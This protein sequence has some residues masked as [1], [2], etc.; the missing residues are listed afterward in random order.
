MFISTTNTKWSILSMRA[1]R[2]RMRISLVCG[3]RLI[4]DK[5]PAAKP[6]G[7]RRLKDEQ[8]EFATTTMAS[9]CFGVV[10][11]FSSGGLCRAILLGLFA[12]S[13]RQGMQVGL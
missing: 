13:L 7:W 8:Y 9:H 6:A 11:R 4:G 1:C 10:L 12:P 2:T 3:G 5:K